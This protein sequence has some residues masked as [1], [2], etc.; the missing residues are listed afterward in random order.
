MRAHKSHA[1][2]FPVLRA[3]NLSLT[4]KVFAKLIDQRE[5]M[6][7]LIRSIFRSDTEKMDGLVKTL[8]IVGVPE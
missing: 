8:Q 5:C 6:F 7:I 2:L 4:F 3:T 1:E